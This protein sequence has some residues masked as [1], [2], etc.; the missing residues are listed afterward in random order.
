[1]ADYNRIQLTKYF[2]QIERTAG[3]AGIYPGMLVEINSD[4]EFVKHTTEG[5]S[6]L[7]AFA[8]EDALQ[9][10]TV[11]DVYT[12]D[13][14]VQAS[15][16][17]QGEEVNALLVAGSDYSTGDYLCSDG[18]G[19][20]ELLSEAGTDADDQVL[21]QVLDAVDLSASGASDTL[22]RVIVL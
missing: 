4:D 12:V 16:P 14:Q 13:E 2:R 1:M 15:I 18:S 11:D 22:T 3:E 20:L 9:G 17:K 8:L 6:A 21:A 7:T 5:G 19:R 10:N